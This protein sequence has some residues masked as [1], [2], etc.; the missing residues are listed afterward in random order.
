MGDT[1]VCVP[2]QNTA[3]EVRRAY[4]RCVREDHGAHKSMTAGDA[5]LTS[6]QEKFARSG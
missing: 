4:M 5:L 3:D 2:A 1:S 6:L